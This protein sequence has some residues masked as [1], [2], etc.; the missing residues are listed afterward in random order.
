MMDRSAAGPYEQRLDP[1]RTGRVVEAAGRH[2][3]HVSTSHPLV[4]A[5][6]G[7]PRRQKL[8][9]GRV[10]FRSVQQCHALNRNGVLTGQHPTNV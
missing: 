10:E 2:S 4:P 8:E 5:A 9:L 1:H 7:Q 3:L 6:A